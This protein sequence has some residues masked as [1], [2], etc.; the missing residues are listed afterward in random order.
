MSR[1]VAS[2]GFMNRV[3]EEAMGNLQKC[4]NVA[5]SPIYSSDFEQLYRQELRSSGSRTYS[6][7]TSKSSSRSGT[8]STRPGTSSNSRNG[9]S[10]GP[11][12]GWL[13]NLFSSSKRDNSSTAG[14][15]QGQLSG[16]DLVIVDPMGYYNVLGLKPGSQVE[17]E[18]IKS[19]YRKLAMQLHPDR[20][21][22]KS[23]RERSRAAQQ[24]ALLLK[25]YDTLKDPEQRRLYESGQL[26][27]ATLNL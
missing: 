24:F 19:A 6:N 22:G 12:G 5:H 17:E 20:Q 13:R 4:L 18:D 2:P 21:A 16:S 23:E 27:E 3:P 8:G 10:K 7:G 9:A 15:S 14:S 25:A 26:I 1:Y 11:S